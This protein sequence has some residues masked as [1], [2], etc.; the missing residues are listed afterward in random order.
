MGFLGAVLAIGQ[1]ACATTFKATVSGVKRL[2]K[3]VATLFLALM[4]GNP[5]LA[6]E[7]IST[8]IASGYGHGPI[9]LPG[10]PCRYE[11][12]VYSVNGSSW[13]DL[14]PAPGGPSNVRYAATPSEI[15]GGSP[16]ASFYTTVNAGILES[17]CGLT[18]VTITSQ[19]S[20]DTD[21]AA[22]DYHG[23]SFRGTLGGTVYDWE[24]AVSGQTGTTII[25]TQKVHVEPTLQLSAAASATTQTVGQNFTYLVTPSVA[26]ATADTAGTLT[27]STTF[28][29]TLTPVSASGTGWSCGAP[30]GQLLSCTSSSVISQGTSGN[31]VTFTVTPNATTASVQPSFSFSGGGASIPAAA[32]PLAVTVNAA[33]ATSLVQPTL[34]LFVGTSANVT[35]VTAT[36]GTPALTWAVTPPLPTGLLMSP[37]TGAITG[38]P[39]ALSSTANYTVSV[40][41]QRG[42]TD[43]E[44][45]SVTVSNLV[46]V[47]SSLSPTNGP[48]AG[49][50]SVVI[51]GQNFA[52]A[53]GVSFGG[54]AATSFVVDSATQITAV[55]PAKSAGQ[56]DVAVTNTNGTSTNTANDDFTYVAAPAIASVS[57]SSGPTA[58]GTSVVITGTDFTGVTA[59]SFGGTAASSY[60]V[61]S[62]TQ[63]TASSPSGAA[64][65]VDI[66]V[67]ATGGISANTINDNFTYVAAPAIASVSPSSGPTAGGTSVVITGTDFTGVTSVSFGGTAASS[68]TVDSATQITATSPAAAAGQVDIAVTATG[69]SSANTI[70]DNFT[71]VA[72]PAIASVSPNTGPTA[73]GTSVV[74]SGTD[75]TGVSAVSF[76]ETAASSFTVDSATQITA[77]SPAGAAGQVDIAVTAIGD[78]SANTANDNFTYVAA[79]AITSLSAS[80]GPFLGGTTLTITG[81]DLSGATKVSFGSTDVLAAAFTSN[82]GT[83]IVLT[84][85]AGTAGAVSVTVTTPYGTSGGATF[86]YIGAPVVQSVSPTVGPLVGGTT[87][88]IIGTD[89]TGASKVSFGAT[90]VL[91]ASFVS[92]NSTTI[93]VDSPAGSAGT[94]TVSVTTPSGASADNGTADDFTYLP[95]PTISGISPATGP[96]A[97]GNTVT[98]TGTGLDYAISVD[99]GGTTIA[100]ASFSSASATAIT[101]AA[102]AHAAGQVNVSVTTT[103]GTSSTAGTTDDYTYVNLPVVSGLVPSAGPLAGGT[104]VVLTGTDFSSA[105]AVK[106]GSNDATS[107]TVDSATQITAVAPAGSAG[108]VDVSVTTPFGTSANN[109]TSE[110]YTYVA[111]PTL[112]AFTHGSTVPYGAGATTIDVATGASPTGSP[113]SY[114]VVS[115]TTSGGGSVSINAAGSASYTPA[116][117]F[118][119]AD[120]FQVTATNVGGTSGAATVTVNVGNPTFVASALPTATI[121]A[122]YSQQVTLSGGTGPYASYSATGLPTGLSISSTGLITGTPSVSGTFASVQITATDSST[123]AFTGTAAAISLIVDP[124]VPDAPTGA[125]AIAGD[126]SAD[127][128]FVAPSFTGGVAITGYT[129]TAAPGGAVAS[130]PSSPITVTGLTNGVSYT[131][132]VVATNNQGD[133]DPSTAS[134]AVTPKQDQTISF[135]GPS[136][137]TNYVPAQTVAVSATA[138]SGLTVEFTSTTTAICTVSGTTVSILSPGTCTIAANQAGD[139]A[140]N[141]AA[142]VTQSFSIGLGNQTLTLTDPADITNFVPNETV[143]LSATASSGLTAISYGTTTPSV[144]TVSGSTATVIAAGT[145]TVT[146]DQAGDSTYNPA[147]QVSQSFDIGLGNQTLT[148]TDPADITSFVPNETVPLSATASSG[149]TA[150]SFGTTTPSVC[151][152]S[153]STATVIA[154]GTCTV[155]ADQ[156][157]DSNYNPAPQVS[158]SFDI[159]LGNQT[160][161][162]DAIA[163]VAPFVLNQTGALSATATSGLT[164]TFATATPSVCSVAG[165]TA[166][167]LTPGTCTVTADQSGDS[168]YNAAAQVSR[169]FTVGGATVEET[170]E[171]IAGF[172]QTRSNHLISSQ[173]GLIGLLAGGGRGGFNLDADSAKGTFSLSSGTQQ[174][175]WVQLNGSWSKSDGFDNSYYFGAVGAHT[176][177]G[178]NTLVGVMLEFD[179]LSQNDGTATSNGTGYLV[180]PYLVSRAANQPLY[181]E[182]RY[183]TGQTWNEVNVH[184]D[185]TDQFET[186]RTLASIKLAGQLTYGTTILTP[187]IGASYLSD[188][189]AE[190]I[191]SISLVIPEQRIEVTDVSIGLDFEQPIATD[192]GALTLTVGITGIWSKTSGTGYA[193]TVVSNYDGG[194]A[195]VDLGLSYQTPAGSRISGGVFVDGI[196]SSGFDSYG[197]DLNFGIEF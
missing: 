84:T 42:S 124:T 94:V 127:V 19:I 45:V 54:T 27:V 8:P 65:Q 165:T 106:F 137:I 87:V 60:T 90:D 22:E 143:T 131:F 53:T 173:P 128:S 174:P 91:A 15:E 151:T 170:Q 139:S 146:A 63:I 138:T 104:S 159:G 35:P 162:F 186:R 30:S 47:I 50:T 7:T 121:N 114:A 86:T 17:I 113:T 190:Y 67:T 116:A 169:S 40:T 161:T 177:L 24:L 160:I 148:M 191:N 3:L 100:A 52:T 150:I 89:L 32:D 164:V 26:A 152:V 197:I 109:G 78:S 141:P 111:A 70:N 155:T 158:Q 33:V 187:S 88:T 166:T 25:N 64:G 5:V 41:D 140:H 129:V 101:L 134:N 57:P 66:A 153:G 80:S 93:V 147:P 103:G 119:G 105:S 123:P 74:I 193:S 185:V 71:Y 28:P 68:Y 46:P 130:G 56:V 189:Q 184:G 144:C 145:C 194:H 6:F 176:N 154:A 107:F 178:P 167:V 39:I 76:G 36:G 99:F 16:T 82:S 149:L 110:D 171:Q 188:T 44:I 29:S 51:T 118:R 58:G 98:I 136:D 59:V 4:W 10:L 1:I 122:A 183:L 163:D 156:A 12:L 181:V 108:A 85:P 120:S 125:S 13:L 180:G 11:S 61:D 69:G 37:T 2:S 31:A 175:V 14:S 43:S 115:G 73:G 195:R 38:S 133:S 117:G 49:G 132:T 179:S 92:A 97:G 95:V 196:G 75:F 135:T 142:E 62:A 48:L 112:S 72:A 20:P 79:P 168:N 157:G 102:P 182:A 23:I 77:T 21:F 172:M 18:S 126:G 192:T 55:S 96:I 83:E 34:S 81:T 9:A